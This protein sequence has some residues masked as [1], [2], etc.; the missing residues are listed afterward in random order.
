MFEDLVFSWL[1]FLG[2]IRR[3]GL[4]VESVAL[5]DKL[6]YWGLALRFQ[7]LIPLCGGLN[8]NGPH[9]LIYLNALSFGNGAT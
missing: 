8:K 6:C 5:L 3:H 1:N 4:I 2:K 9:S 7:K